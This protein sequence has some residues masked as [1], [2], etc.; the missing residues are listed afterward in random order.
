VPQSVHRPNGA[1][2]VTYT[3]ELVNISRRVGEPYERGRPAID[4]SG[5][6]VFVGSSDRGL[7]AL[8][9]EDGTT[10]W[11]FETLAPVQGEPLY[12]A[13]EDVLYFG[14]NDGALYKV[15]AADG[16]LLWRIATNAEISRQPRLVE[17]TLYVVNANDTVVALK[18]A[19]GSML[20][21]QHRTPA[22]GMSIAGHAGLL[23]SGDRVFA[24][25]SDGN[26]VAFDARTGNERWQPVDLGADAERLL[27]EP[28]KYLD[29]DTTPVPGVSQGIPVI[30]VASYEGGVYALDA[31]TG[32]EVWA[33]HAVRGA[34]EL[35]PW[36]EPAHPARDG[37]GD[38]PSRRM[39]IVSTG[40]SGLWA[41]DPETGAE[42]W[43]QPI[44]RGGISAPVP[45]AG[46]LLVTT[47]QLGVF[48]VN[49]LD[50]HVMD[51]LDMVSGA[52]MTPAV[53][54]HRA[55]VVGNAGRLLALTVDPP[56]AAHVDRWLP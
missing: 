33:Q 7:Y 4:V 47:S 48:L 10:L 27:G 19:D 29:V 51:G 12:D 54:G 15:K 36:S 1:L 31:D 28:P 37:K 8:R 50:G 49:P 13:A 23:V 53:A 21:T 3:R 11:R 40:T 22:A 24:A 5:R 20:W 26:V 14:S 43:R 46:A 52:A 45:I 30:Y 32:M 56:R 25:F 38:V 35:L 2:A 17:G 44:P 42:L 55:F 6:R 41:L 18:A 9:A 34:A 16:Q 39:L